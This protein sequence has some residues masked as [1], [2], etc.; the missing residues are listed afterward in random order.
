MQKVRR[1]AIDIQ[2]GLE[3]SWI[4]PCK[5]RTG[6]NPLKL[7]RYFRSSSKNPDHLGAI[8]AFEVH[9]VARLCTTAR[10]GDC[11]YRRFNPHADIQ[12]LSK[13][14]AGTLSIVRLQRYDFTAPRTWSA[15]RRTQASGEPER[16]VDLMKS[17]L[18]CS[19]VLGLAIVAAPVAADGDAS[20]YMTVKQV[21]F[22]G[23]PPFRRSTERLPAADIA[24]LEQVAAPVDRV[25]TTDFRGR[26]PFARNVEMLPLTSVAR[27]EAVGEEEKA[28]PR[29][30][31]RLPGFR[32]HAR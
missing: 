30:R 14:T 17:V 8:G 4:D 7:L 15:A 20:G 9:R 23:R 18:S 26:P 1:A 5:T 25:R 27:L 28:G 19:L 13:I 12:N 10:R 16:G 3:R 22:S 21:D 6:F 2:P 29:L 32:G 31:S 24:R 11:E